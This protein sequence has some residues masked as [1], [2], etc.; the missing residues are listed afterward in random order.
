[1]RSWAGALTDSLLDAFS[2]AAAAHPD[3]TALVEGDGR[4]V[5]FAALRARVDTLAAAWHARGLG[6]GDRALIAMPLG[7]D[8]YAGL[9]ALWSLGATAVLP[10]PAM[11]L[12]GLRHALRLAGCTALV[13]AGPYRWLKLLPALWRLPLYQPQAHAGAPRP[14]HP[15]APGDIALISFTSGSTGLPKAIPRS[16]AFLQAQRRAVAPLLDGPEP[17]V[18]LVAFPVFVLV[19]L[20]AGRTSVLPNWRMTRLDRVQPAALADWIAD[21][22]VTRALLP[23][24]LCDTLA[25]HA[26]PPRLHSVFTGG[27]PVFPDVIARLQARRPDLRLVAVYGSTEAEPI[28]ELDMA[29]VTDADRAAMQSGRG[30]LAG[31]PVPGLRLQIREGEVVVAGAHVNGGYLDPSRD[32]ETKIRDG[33]T[34]WHR[35]GDAGHLD[36]QGRL[37]LLGRHGAEVAGLAPFAVETAVRTW[38][39]IRAAALVAIDGSPVLALEGDTA[40]RAT[41]T[42]EAAH[43]G[44][45]DLRPVAQIP[46][47]RRHRSKVDY[48]ALKA[49]LA[50]R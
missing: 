25:G 28:A 3:R 38:P 20:A 21:Q 47:D 22:R 48:P 11:G 9:A 31:P 49:L 50:R 19:N 18:D 15:G 35:T 10:E 13:A 1:M 26:I 39:G 6:P 34:I 4:A 27:G 44:L 5:T 17:E 42:A 43:L 32:V 46:L 24:R 7:A 37:W 33:D 45:T 29:T 16:H 14:P 30:L 40:H 41:W 36:D 2:A 8:L 12:P 23:P